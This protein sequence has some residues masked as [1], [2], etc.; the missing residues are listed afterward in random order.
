LCT[1]RSGMDTHASAYGAK[2]TVWETLGV[3]LHFK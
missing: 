1:P 2:S 3:Y